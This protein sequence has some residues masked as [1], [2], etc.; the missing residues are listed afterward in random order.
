MVVLVLDAAGQQVLGFQF[1]PVAVAVLC[2]DLDGC[3]AG[4]GAVVAR[5]GQA[6]S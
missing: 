5:E 6:A 3:G 4:H 1:K 2:A